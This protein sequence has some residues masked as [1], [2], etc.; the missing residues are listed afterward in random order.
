MI[1]VSTG[2]VAFSNAYF[3]AGIGSQLLDSVACIGSEIMLTSCSSSSNIY[4][5]NGHYEDA[6]VRCQGLYI[7]QAL[8]ISLCH[9]IFPYCNS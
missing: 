1:D 7:M 6:G 4:C 8:I 5:Y 2:A 3:G 9:H